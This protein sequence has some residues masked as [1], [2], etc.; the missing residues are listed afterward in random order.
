LRYV[1]THTLGHFGFSFVLN[2][3]QIA[4]IPGGLFNVRQVK[5]LR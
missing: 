1:I 5:A 2:A 3:W 4:A